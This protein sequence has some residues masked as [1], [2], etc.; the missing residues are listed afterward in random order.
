MQ[1]LSR[2]RPV[3]LNAAAMASYENQSRQS[4]DCRC[5]ASLKYI[6]IRFSL[7]CPHN[8]SIVPQVPCQGKNDLPDN[9]LEAGLVPLDNLLT[10]DAVGGANL[11][12]ATATL[13][14]ALTT[15]THADVEVHSVN[16]DSWVVL[17]AEI[18]VLGDSETEV[19]GLREVALAELVLLNLQATLEDLL[20]LWATDG[21]MDRD[22]LVTADTE[23]TDSVAGLACAS[24]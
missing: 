8:T 13:G 6:G 22:L 3:G 21:D 20:G 16:S 5:K 24:C 14:D 19:T 4:E 9:S 12:L 11:G 18:D 7:L 10:L 23:G 15:A 1:G 17:D 2:P